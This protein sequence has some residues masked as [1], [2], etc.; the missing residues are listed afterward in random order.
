MNAC[1][2][3]SAAHNFRELHR[4]SIAVLTGKGL[5]VSFF[6]SNLPAANTTACRGQQFACELR[7]ERDCARVW[8]FKKK[9]LPRIFKPKREDGE[10]HN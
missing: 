1:L 7:V 3:K 10:K 8:G 5:E 2:H 6:I 4:C 9:I